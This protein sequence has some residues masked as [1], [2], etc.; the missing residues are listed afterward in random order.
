M[1]MQKPNTSDVVGCWQPRA[2]WRRARS[3]IAAGQ[4]SSP[5]IIEQVLVKVNGDIITKTELEERQI[6]ALRE[7]K[8]SPEVLKNDE[9]LKKA[10]AEVTPQLLVAAVDELLVI[11]LGREKGLRL[12][13][14]QF[15]RWLTSMRKDQNLEDD[16][17]FEAALK[18]EGMAIS[19]IRRNVEKQFLLTQVQTEEFGGKLQITRKRRGSTTTPTRRNSSSRRRSPSANR[20]RCRRGRVRCE[21]LGTAVLSGRACGSDER[22]E[23]VAD[24]DAEVLQP[25]LVDALVNGRDELD[26]RDDLAVEDLRAALRER[27]TRSGDRSRRSRGWR[28]RGVRAGSSRACTGPTRAHGR[29]GG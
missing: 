24:H 17:K 7:R 29:R 18:Q 12:S 5:Q 13:D 6:G 14:E 26:E 10:L 21:G 22:V 20:T 1:K 16:K 11:Q 25:H 15:N 9:Q 23:R 8:I 4:A 2:C 27:S 3:P 28:P 19:D